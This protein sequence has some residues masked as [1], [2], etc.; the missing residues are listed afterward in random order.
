MV[1]ILDVT[2]ILQYFNLK[3]LKINKDEGICRSNSIIFNNLY[4][5]NIISNNL[6]IEKIILHTGTDWRKN[7]FTRLIMYNYNCSALNKEL[8]N[9][10]IMGVH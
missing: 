7:L 5:N 9:W 6:I 8:K 3:W 10:L 1:V 4:Y 2:M